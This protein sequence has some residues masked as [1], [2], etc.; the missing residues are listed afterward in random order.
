M[1]KILIIGGTGM[2]ASRFI[3]LVKGQFDITSVDEKTLD[4]TNKEVVVKY[5][6]DNPGFNAVVNFAAFTNVDGAE[7]QKDD[8]NS[9]SWKLNVEGPQNLA[10]ECKSAN[11]FLVHISTDF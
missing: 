6:T 3:D 10:E 1:K 9:L 5:F 8:K 2:V 11:I 4:I 7:A